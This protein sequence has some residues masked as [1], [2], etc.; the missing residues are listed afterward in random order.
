M[1]PYNTV[2]DLS[3]LLT[4]IIE[5]PIIL[6]TAWYIIMFD[7]REI[8]AIGRDVYMSQDRCRG[9]S[10]RFYIISL[11]LKSK[12]FINFIGMSNIISDEL[13]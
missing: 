7:D 1:E 6:P 11:T 10:L 4:V 13:K 2:L 3:I 12:H 5:H 9:R 8:E